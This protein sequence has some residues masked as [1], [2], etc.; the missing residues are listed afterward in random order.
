MKVAIAEPSAQLV[1]AVER[2]LAGSS[3]RVLWHTSSG[4]DALKHCAAEPPDILLLGLRVGDIKPAELTRRLVANRTCAVVLMA[5]P[6][7]ELSSAYDAMGAGALDVVKTPTFDDDGEL[8]GAELLRG[9]IR[10]AGRLLGHAS[11]GNLPVAQ[12]GGSPAALPPLI[13]IGA[14]T[15]GPQAILTVLSALPKPF[16]GA[17]VIVQHVDGEFSAGLASWLAETSGLRVELARPGSVPTVGMALLAGTEEHLIMAAGGSLRYTPTPRELPYRPSV[18]VLFTSLVQHWK[19]PGVAALLTGMG[20][21]GAQGL[22]K[23][24]QAGW[25]TI[26]QDEASSVVYGMPKAAAQLGA[27]ARV[28]ALVDIAPEISSF[29]LRRS[30]T[31]KT[32][33]SKRP[34][35]A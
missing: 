5:G 14:S 32:R 13:A 33:A 30:A 20:R 12:L 27:A 1:R 34:G 28:L 25:L 17:L 23:L 26:A 9:K 8:I 16:A 7:S 24:R 22:K 31:R 11:S 4:R 19:A 3:H 35:R 6:D 29:A 21:D 18:D 15:G 10:T 2:A